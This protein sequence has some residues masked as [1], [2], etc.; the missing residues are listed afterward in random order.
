LPLVSA[1]GFVI[2][3]VTYILYLSNME[4]LD[5]I[6]AVMDCVYTWSG[7]NPTFDFIADKLKHLHI[8][9][10][11]IQDILLFF[12]Q[13]NQIYCVLDEER[14]IPFTDSKKAHYLINARG[15]IF[16]EQNKGYKK[17]AKRFKRRKIYEWLVNLSLILG[18]LFAA[19]YYAVELW[20]IFF[21]P[22]SIVH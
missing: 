2:Y 12:Y 9:D 1:G 8:D 21:Q 17:E 22:S 5:K 10:G 18:G 13:E 16:W 19:A 6:D 11:E 20:K 3:K 4:W 14:T 7:K 15:K